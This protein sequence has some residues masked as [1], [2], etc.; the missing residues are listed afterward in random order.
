MKKNPSP[1]GYCRSGYGQ[2]ENC[3]E[4]GNELS[5][6][7]NEGNFLASLK[8]ISCSMGLVSYLVNGLFKDSLLETNPR[9]RL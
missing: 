8:P 1:K 4:F 6:S 7:I 9:G 3:C 5:G 2:V